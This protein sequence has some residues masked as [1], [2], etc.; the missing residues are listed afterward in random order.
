[1][2]GKKLWLFGLHFVHVVCWCVLWIRT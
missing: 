2:S 1:M